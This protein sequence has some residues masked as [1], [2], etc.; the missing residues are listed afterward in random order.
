MHFFIAYRVRK[1]DTKGF[2]ANINVFIHRYAWKQNSFKCYKNLEI[3]EDNE[4]KT[5]QD[6]SHILDHKNLTNHKI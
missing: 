6:F 1:C 3:P 5:R 2:K 4:N